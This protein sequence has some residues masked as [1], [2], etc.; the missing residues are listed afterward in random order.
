MI[1]IEMTSASLLGGEPTVSPMRLEGMEAARMGLG[2]DVDDSFGE[3]GSGV[4]ETLPRC[5]KGGGSSERKGGGGC[6]VSSADDGGVLAGCGFGDCDGFWF[7]GWEGENGCRLCVGWD[8]FICR[9]SDIGLSC[10]CIWY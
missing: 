6:D 1:G 7:G 8:G 10:N 2:G 3:V 4:R 5:R 9:R